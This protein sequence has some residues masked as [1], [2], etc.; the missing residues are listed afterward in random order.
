MGGKR[1]IIKSNLVKIATTVWDFAKNELMCAI[2]EYKIKELVKKTESS[3][4]TER[5]LARAKLKKDFPEI[6]HELKGDG[7]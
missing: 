7:K 6:Y 3:K 2:E 4:L 5:A 1:K